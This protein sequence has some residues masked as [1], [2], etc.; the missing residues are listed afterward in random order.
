MTKGDPQGDSTMSTI[1]AWQSNEHVDSDMLTICCPKCEN[2]LTLHQ[3]D[4]E[5]ADRLLATC[6]DCKSWFLTDAAGSSL[7]A[8]PELLDDPL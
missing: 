6:E 4:E 2:P 8:L 5:L 1:F 7:L 3:P